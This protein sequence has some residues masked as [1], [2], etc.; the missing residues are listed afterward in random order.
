MFSINGLSRTVVVLL[1]VNVDLLVV[2]NLQILLMKIT[3]WLE[4]VAPKL[5]VVLTSAGVGFSID[6]K[7]GAYTKLQIEEVIFPAYHPNQ[8]VQVIQ[9]KL[10]GSHKLFRQDTLK[11][12]CNRATGK[13]S[14][15]NRLLE[16]CICVLQAEALATICKQRINLVK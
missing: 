4:E 11:E 1:I 9:N 16:L 6:L 12:V 7:N 14:D 5:I 13:S 2:A 10:Q 8:L 3:K 15:V